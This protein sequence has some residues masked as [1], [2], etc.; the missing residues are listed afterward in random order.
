[1]LS[2]LYYLCDFPSLVAM[3]EPVA[4]PKAVAR[5]DALPKVKFGNSDMMVT[6]VCGGTM[7]WG[8]FNGKEEEA[9]EQLDKL[10]ELG[11]NFI[12]TAELYP[13]AF[14]YGQTT[15]IWIGNWLEKSVAAGKVKREELYLATK[16][17]P[18]GIGTPAMEGF[19]PGQAHGYEDHILMHA[20]KS[21]MERMKVDYIDLYQLHFPVRDI[22]LFGSAVFHPDGKHRP[23]KFVNKG[24][25]DTFDKQVLSVKKLFDAGLI[26]HWG[27]SNENA[28]G[29]CMFCMSCD[30]LGVPRPVSCQNDFSMVDRIYES[31]TWEAAYRFG[32][33]GLPYGPLAGG[34]LTGKYLKDSKYATVDKAR[35]LAECRMRSQPEFQPR[36]GFPEAMR[37]TEKYVALAEEWGLTPT[38]LALAWARDRP[39][40][41]SIIIGSTTV[42]Q[43]E[44]CVGAFLLETLPEELMNAVDAIH[45]EIRNPCCYYCDKAHAMAAPW[46]AEGISACGKGGVLSVEGRLR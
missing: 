25:P 43:V 2:V 34:V 5:R 12:D 24:E 3:A 45:E 20:C 4:T 9:V 6:E 8:S 15:E 21:S 28:Y 39:C 33:V 18:A 32:V 41:T 29:I 16:C 27:L 1:L 17:N 7:T 42:R 38:E 19:E 13:V 37:A 23:F 22:P 44:E 11:V 40:N 26:K 35:P 10:I 30:K 46:L 31:D 14:N 36:Y